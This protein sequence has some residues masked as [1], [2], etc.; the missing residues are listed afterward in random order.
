MKKF[1]ANIGIVLGYIL[2]V[3][4]I[5]RAI[6]ELFIIDYGDAA[7]YK[8]DWGGPSLVGVLAV[9]VIPGIISLALIV[10][11]QRNRRKTP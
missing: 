6:V 4:L 9:H 3:Y 2:G 11:Y 8:N 7:S 1:F 5:I 10:R